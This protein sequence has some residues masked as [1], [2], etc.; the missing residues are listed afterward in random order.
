MLSMPQNDV[1]CYIEARYVICSAQHES[2]LG[3]GLG[4]QLPLLGPIQGFEKRSW[5]LDSHSRV[6]HVRG[7]HQ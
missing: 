3:A 7:Q 1:V 4:T 2:G 5:L 6:G